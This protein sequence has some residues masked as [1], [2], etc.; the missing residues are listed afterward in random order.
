MSPMVRCRRLT[1]MPGR[2]NGGSLL[3]GVGIARSAYAPTSEQAAKAARSVRRMCPN[4]A[5]LIL[6]ML[7]LETDG[8]TESH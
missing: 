5:E 3:G 6:D 7:G 2:D 4:D 8:S 1:Y